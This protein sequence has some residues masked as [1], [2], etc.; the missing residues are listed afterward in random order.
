MAK[1]I[2]FNII[3]ADL[4]RYF[5][6]SRAIPKEADTE[7]YYIIFSFSKYIFI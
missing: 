4:V 6:I 3:E 2:F 5:G 1:Y 7:I